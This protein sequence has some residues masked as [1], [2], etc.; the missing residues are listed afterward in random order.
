MSAIHI[1]S[2]QLRAIMHDPELYPDPFTFSPDRFVRVNDADAKRCS[3]YDKCQLD[4]RTFAF[5]FG[6]RTC[7]GKQRFTFKPSNIMFLFSIS[8]IGVHFAE[9]SM[10]LNMASIVSK[11][12]ITLPP[13]KPIPEVR[14]TTGITRFVPL[15][16]VGRSS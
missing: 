7:P 12:D 3:T 4:S 5:G 15:Y 13:E 1:I 2:H 14:F 8:T 16:S 6:R 10:M 11:F 9:T